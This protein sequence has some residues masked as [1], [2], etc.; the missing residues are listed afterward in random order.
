MLAAWYSFLTTLLPLAGSVAILALLAWLFVSAKQR[1]PAVRALTRLLFLTRFS[2]L[3]GLLLPGLVPLAWWLA[4]GL[5]GNLFVLDGPVQLVAVTFL[6]LV[7]AAMV[8]VTFRVT[9]FNAP[10][11]FIDYEHFLKASPWM[12]P[13]PFPLPPDEPRK[14]DWCGRWLWLAL[15]GLPVPLAC[16]R[17]T[18]TDLS[19]TGSLWGWGSF[20]PDAVLLAWNAVLGVIGLLLGAGLAVLLLAAL[21]ALQEW[22]IHPDRR[23][24]DLLPFESYRWL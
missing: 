22:L 13:S 5:L 11:R 20:A 7:V 24:P 14:H 6:S 8:L 2:L 18:V 10:V 3:F 23:S 9:Q 12:Q 15:M 21:V 16:W 1:W 19:H 4:P 17:A